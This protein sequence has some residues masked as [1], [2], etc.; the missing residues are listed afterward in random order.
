MANKN[1]WNKGRKGERWLGDEVG[2][3]GIHMWL[4]REHGYPPKCEECGLIGKKINSRW[5]IEW[6]LV[7]GEKYERKRENFRML[8]HGC[9]MKYDFTEEWRKSLSDSHKG[10]VP[11]MTGRKHTPGALKK[12]SETG[13]GRAPWNK[14][15][16]WSAVAK[17]K[18]S[19]AH[20]GI[21]LKHSGQFKK[22]QI[23][24]NKKPTVS[25]SD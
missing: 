7:K 1:P 22:G 14:G 8:C 19:I 5:N 3:F 6:A 18:M 23:P 11:W 2:Y 12:I 21:P 24:W 16:P 25:F 13:K 20:K 10:Q 15:K 9:H 17:R 4:T